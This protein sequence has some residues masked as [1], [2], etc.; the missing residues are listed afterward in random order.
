[1]DWLFFRTGL[2]SSTTKSC[3]LIHL[4][5]AASSK[6]RTYCWKQDIR[7]AIRAKKDAFQTLLQKRSLSDLQCDLRYVRGNLE[8]KHADHFIFH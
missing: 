6:K 3:E 7:E 8:N 5:M 4:R 1:M 2:I